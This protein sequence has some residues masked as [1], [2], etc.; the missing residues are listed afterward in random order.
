MIAEAMTDEAFAL[1]V[2][3]AIALFVLLGLVAMV[4]LW[5]WEDVWKFPTRRLGAWWNARKS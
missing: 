4:A 1:G 2:L 3:G 5:L